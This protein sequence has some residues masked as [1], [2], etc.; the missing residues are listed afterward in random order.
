MSNNENLQRVFHQ[1]EAM[2]GRAATTREAVAWAIAN[3]ILPVPKLD[4]VQQLAEAMSRA[5]REEY[6][7]D[8]LGRR[9]R[10]SH[11]VSTTNGECAQTVW[12]NMLEAPRNYMVKAFAQRR[13]QIVG[14]CYQ[15]KTDVDVYNDT[16]R[17]AEPIQT[18]LDFTND[19]VELQLAD[20]A[21]DAA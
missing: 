20:Q 15:L 21:D 9:Y 11:A 16:H 10:V 12:R 3:N 5:L 13:K 6:R 2:Q 8:R 18:C 14:D 19:V 1:Y 17:A 7:T 4:P